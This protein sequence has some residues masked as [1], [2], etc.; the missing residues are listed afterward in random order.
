MP[1]NFKIIYKKLEEAKSS[2]QLS[3]DILVVNKNEA[4]LSEI[5][6]INELRKMI[7]EVN[8]PDPHTYTSS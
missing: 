8:D 7:L 3:D 4:T 5:D 1:N 6:E 2:S